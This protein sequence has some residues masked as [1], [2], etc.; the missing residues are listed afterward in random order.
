MRRLAIEAG[1]ETSSLWRFMNNP[2][3]NLN[4]DCLFKLWPCIYG[5]QKPMPIVLRRAGN[6][7]PTKASK[8]S[9]PE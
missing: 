2:D 4:T 9:S 1:I 7:F 5:T 3:A 8:I 6:V